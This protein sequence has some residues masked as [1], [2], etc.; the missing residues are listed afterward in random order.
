MIECKEKVSQLHA[1]FASSYINTNQEQKNKQIRKENI[2][3]NKEVSQKV[4][5]RLAQILK[6]E[7]F[8]G[9]IK[10]EKPIYKV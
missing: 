9:R 2:S 1:D 3:K 4:Y 8:Q 10:R 6:W 7:L 5:I